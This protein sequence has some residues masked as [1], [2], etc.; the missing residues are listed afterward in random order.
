MQVTI[1]FD[2]EDYGDIAKFEEIHG[3]IITID[4]ALMADELPEEFRDDIIRLER[5][6][7]WRTLNSLN[8]YLKKSTDHDRAY[9]VHLF[10][11]HGLEQALAEVKKVMLLPL[12]TGTF[13][14]HNGTT[15]R[16]AAKG[17]T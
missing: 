1:A 13:F 14:T 2:V 3:D 6:G 9:L 5:S 7:S 10:K 4:D 17:I 15:Y 11:I 16:A 8:E 12:D